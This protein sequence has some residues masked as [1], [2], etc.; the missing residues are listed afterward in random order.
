MESKIKNTYN[1]PIELEDG[2]SQMEKDLV[3]AIYDENASTTRITI[4]PET[5]K[6]QEEGLA[7][8]IARALVTQTENKEG[9]PVLLSEK[10]Y[11]TPENILQHDIKYGVIKQPLKMNEITHEI[12][13][14]TEYH[15]LISHK[16][17]YHFQDVPDENIV[18]NPSTKPS[19]Y[20]EI[21][22]ITG[23]ERAQKYMKKT[24][25]PEDKKAV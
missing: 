19:Q 8:V 5:T 17:K 14:P 12:V 11:K 10:Y 9:E 1:N 18:I 6:K 3:N 13:I 4:P 23:K 24:L 15:V 21:T 16:H 22:I 7:W 20:K 2:L 25:L